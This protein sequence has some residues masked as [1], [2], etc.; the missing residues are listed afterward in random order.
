MPD[1]ELVTIENSLLY[2][3]EKV[4]LPAGHKKRRANNVANGADPPKRT[5][6]N[7]TKNY[8]TS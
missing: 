5:D 7:L 4:I 1:E 3:K 8:E 6:P 2:C